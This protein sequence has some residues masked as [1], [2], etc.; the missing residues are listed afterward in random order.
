MQRIFYLIKEQVYA[1]WLSYM[2]AVAGG[3][4]K[5][6]D[7]PLPSWANSS[8]LRGDLMLFSS[9]GSQKHNKFL[10]RLNLTVEPGTFYNPMGARPV[11]YLLSIMINGLCIQRVLF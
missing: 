4:N 9:P 11:L 8:G 7:W 3:S 6:F 2:S 5:M 1:T 10:R